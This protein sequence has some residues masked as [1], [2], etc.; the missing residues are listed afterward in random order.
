M[1][2]EKDA[3]LCAKYPKIFSNR[4]NPS[5]PIGC[6]GCEC[7]DGWFDLIDTLCLSIQSHIDSEV[8]C[9]NLSKTAVIKLQVKAEQIKE[10]FGELRFYVSGGDD[11]TR[12]MISFA[13]LMSKHICESCGNKAT[14]RTSGWIRNLCQSCA[15]DRAS[16]RNSDK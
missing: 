4:D 8:K 7:D 12:G 10:K 6:S 16:Q 11:T 2:P 5:E 1:S 14:V 9:N 3:E 15:D 13:E